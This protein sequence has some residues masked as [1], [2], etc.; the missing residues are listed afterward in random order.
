M[1]PAGPPGTGGGEIPPGAMYKVLL[2]PETEEE[3]GDF[4]LDIQNEYD[5]WE[6]PT[7]VSVDLQFKEPVGPELLNSYEMICVATLPFEEQDPETGEWHFVDMR[8]LVSFLFRAGW[9]TC[10]FR[11]EFPDRNPLLDLGA[12][13]IE[14]YILF[15]ALF[16]MEHTFPVDWREDGLH[17]AF[18]PES[19]SFDNIVDFV[20]VLIHQSLAE[21]FGGLSE[22]E[23]YAEI[24]MIKTGVMEE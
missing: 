12:D 9:P 20:N 14:L 17:F 6:N 24:K 18:S 1:G 4:S 23:D 7:G 5:E 2:Q 21:F 3:P 13:S 16:N 22:L 11:F 10:R 19:L 15:F 8:V